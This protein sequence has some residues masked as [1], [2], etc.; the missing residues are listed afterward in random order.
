MP[1]S[2]SSSSSP[3]PS[4]SRSGKSSRSSSPA[5]SPSMLRP[6]LM[7]RWMRPAKRVGSS[8]EKPDVNSDVSYS[9]QMRSL[10]V[11]SDLSFSAFSR[12]ATTIGCV[13]FTSIDFFDIMAADMLL[14]R[15]AC[16]FMMR[17]ML[18]DQPY[19]PVTRQHGDSSRRADTIT[20]STLSPS[21]SLITLHRPSVLAVASSSAFFSSSDSSILRPSLVAEM[22]F[23]PSYSLSCCTAYS[24]IGSTMNSTSKPFFFSFSRNGESSTAFWL[25][26]VM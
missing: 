25:S 4:A 15:S 22:S 11:L 2:S 3:S 17:S 26:P 9:S 10:T 18:A 16:A 7:R 24:S 5:S 21:T 14:S 6:S 1:P 13:G 8:N 12:S 20:F 19:S 23:L